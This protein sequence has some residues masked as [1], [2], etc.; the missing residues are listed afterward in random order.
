[1]KAYD[2]GYYCFYCLV[3]KKPEDQSHIRALALFGIALTNLFVDILLAALLL[4]PY[5]FNR[6]FFFGFIALL[7]ILNVVVNK[8]ENK[9]FLDSGRYQ[10]V[11]NNFNSRFTRVQQ[12][13]FGFVAL[14]FFLLPI[15][16]FIWIGINLGST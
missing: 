4:S 15:S 5:E 1:M 14:L 10:K 16:L 9:Y 7:L 8:L 2:F 6:A 12:R 11:I 3:I 13:F